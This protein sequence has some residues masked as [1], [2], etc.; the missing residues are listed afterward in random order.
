MPCIEYMLESRKKTGQR[1]DFLG[2]NY[3]KTYIKYQGGSQLKGLIATPCRT[4][5]K[6]TQ[7]EGIGKELGFE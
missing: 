3:V 7:G 6:E 4:A 1:A 5:T 2:R